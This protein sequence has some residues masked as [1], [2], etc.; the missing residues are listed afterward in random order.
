VS[1]VFENGFPARATLS[2]GNE[3]PGSV[4]KRALGDP[5]L[6][7]LKIL[8]RGNSSKWRYEEFLAALDD[9]HNTK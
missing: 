8:S 1:V 3:A 9:L 6:A 4:W 2:R 7:T 5:R